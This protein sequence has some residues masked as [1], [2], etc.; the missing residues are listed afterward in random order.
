M[1]RFLSE[2]LQA[3]EPYFRLA[4]SR[5]EAANGHSSA[6][7]Q[8]SSE[9]QQATRAK[10]QQL[11]LDPDNTTAEEL[12][13]T[14]VRR[15]AI[16]DRRLTQALRTRAASYVSA[17]GD[18]VGGM[19][20][21]LRGVLDNRRCFALK[22]SSLKSLLQK[23]PP[24][25][26]IKRLG[27]RSQASCLKHESPVLIMAA[28]W[29]CEGETWRKHL[30]EQYKKLRANDFEDRALQFIEP[31][32]RHWQQL[33]AE[34]V[35]RDKQNV[36]SFR[37]CGTL[38]FLPLPAEIPAGVVTASLSLAL[39]ELN[40]IRA[41]SSFLKLGQLRP[42]FG[43]LVQTVATDEPRLQSRMLDQ[44][45]PWRLIQRY[46]SRLTHLFRE[47]IFE[48]SLQLEDMIWQPIEQTLSEIEPSFA[49]WQHSG[50]LGLLHDRQPVSLNII[51]AALNCCNHL[52]FEQRV[53]EYFQHSLWHEL[54]LRY[55]QPE[56][57]EQTM[58]AELQPQLAEAEVTL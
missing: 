32:S 58:V 20:H 25:K 48:P 50:H 18:V 21:A 37:E 27:Y 8:L 17:D 34:V 1:T 15:L 31:A 3:P 36:I 11:G 14:L 42:D 5:L 40:E 26:A 4:L 33:A 22:T 51:D 46:Y 28:G 19:V 10:L 55:L 44:P 30:A 53:V 23:V 52:P 56:T 6:D 7:I 16:D 43:S 47:E 35:A 24:K 13:Q 57:V 9:V 39:H 38:V 12:Y 41:G 54:L 45:V 29:L 2:S 49:F